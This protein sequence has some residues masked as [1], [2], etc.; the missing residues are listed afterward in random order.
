MTSKTEIYK[1][2]EKLF[3]CSSDVSSYIDLASFLAKSKKEYEMAYYVG[4]HSLK[5]LEVLEEDRKE[6]KRRSDYLFDLEGEQKKLGRFHQDLELLNQITLEREIVNKMPGFMLLGENE[7]QNLALRTILL[8]VETAF[9]RKKDIVA[10]LERDRKTID[11]FGLDD[12]I[13]EVLDKFVPMLQAPPHI[14]RVTELVRSNNAYDLC[15]DILENIFPL[16]NDLKRTLKERK[17]LEVKQSVLEKEKKQYEKRK[18]QFPAEKDELLQSVTEE[19]KSNP[20]PYYGGLDLNSIDDI[21]K[22]GFEVA[23]QILRS[24]VSLKQ[25]SLSKRKALDEGKRMDKM[26]KKEVF[27]LDPTT[28]NDLINQKIKYCLRSENIN[29]P[30]HMLELARIFSETKETEF[31]PIV[32]EKLREALKR[33]AS[34]KEEKEEKKANFERYKEMREEA[35]NKWETLDPEVEQEYYKITF[36]FLIEKQTTP[37]YATLSKQKLEDLDLNILK[38]MLDSIYDRR[39]NFLKSNEASDNP[40]TGK[41]L[42]EK[43]KSFQQEVVDITY[44]VQNPHHLYKIAKHIH[45]RND[46]EIV[47][48]IGEKCQNITAEVDAMRL[49][50]A[51]LTAKKNELEEEKADL[52]SRNRTFPASKEIELSDVSSE[53]MGLPEWPVYADLFDYNEFDELNLEVVRLMTSAILD[54]KKALEDSI[55]KMFKEMN[56]KLIDHEGIERD[57]EEIED[58]IKSLTKEC[59]DRFEN[60][61]YLLKFLNDMHARKETQIVIEVCNKCVNSINEITDKRNERRPIILEI[62]KLKEDIE[63]GKKK[64]KNFPEKLIKVQELEIKLKSLPQWPHF[65]DVY[66]GN[67]YDKTLLSSLSNALISSL[68][69]EDQTEEKIA[70]EYFYDRTAVDPEKTRQMRETARTM[71]DDMVD[72]CLDNIKNPYHLYEIIEKC[73]KKNKD[74]LVVKMGEGMFKVLN[75]L[76]KQREKRDKLQTQID[77]LSEEEELLS[78]RKRTLAADVMADLEKMREMNRNAQYPDYLT[79][80]TDLSKLSD[81]LT[82]LLLS[83]VFNCKRDLEKKIEEDRELT[84]DRIYELQ[85]EQNNTVDMCIRTILTYMDNPIQ[86]IDSC[87]FL[88]DRKEYDAAYSL[89][90]HCYQKIDELISVRSKREKEEAARDKLLKEEKQL[91]ERRKQLSPK[92]KKRLRALDMNR[93]LFVK[94]PPYYRPN[95]DYDELSLRLANIMIFGA[96]EESENY[97]EKAG[98]NDDITADELEQKQAEHEEKIK[99]IVDGCLKYISN[100]KNLITLASSLLQRRLFIHAISAGK[101]C[102]VIIQQKWGELVERQHLKDK[103]DELDQE[104]LKILVSQTFDDAPSKVE[105]PEDLKKKIKKAKKAI[106]TLPELDFDGDDLNRYLLEISDVVVQAAH[107]ED[108][109]EIILEQKILAFKADTS[110]ER[111]D[112][113][114]NIT[115]D[116][117]EWDRIKQDLVVY[118]LKRDDK[119]REK[120]ELLLRDGLYKHCLDIFP[121]PSGEED[122]LDLLYRVY[123]TIEENEPE[124]LEESIQIIARYMRFYFARHKYTDLT[125][126]LDRVQRRFP[127]IIIGLYSQAVD[128][129]LVNLLQSQY[130]DFVQCMQDLKNRL[131]EV[132]KLDDWNEFADKFSKKHKGKKRLMQMMEFLNDGTFDIAEL[133]PRKKRKRE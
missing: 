77:I 83:C 72:L 16:L 85:V 109:F 48:L 6:R 10:A 100:I 91:D 104:R 132:N 126:I 39:D 103:F 47:R 116:V 51:P 87:K 97:I 130:A 78:A 119:P 111:W 55:A 124:L 7:I 28:I 81:K 82:N 64:K 128:L 66:D 13:K 5:T 112:Q 105:I 20:I 76:E 92:D 12:K 118:V 31:I 107:A 27:Y 49:V 68:E 46:S 45:Q 43:K 1:V 11:D 86:L 19:L 121:K 71:I 8:M 23:K 38:F 18:T 101:R 29:D 17:E 50:R 36:D 114:R 15:F 122:E 65:A 33:I 30:N 96:V 67:Q 131:E 79:N 2:I 99:Q 3:G 73:M 57:R 125:R 90:N 129:V 98:S 62:E 14:L 75:E 37:S 133:R 113:V 120:C 25:T 52:E 9:D 24:A 32:G 21:E 60:P 4:E 80:T 70:K 44:E 123:D 108:L 95:V 102:E 41:F 93:R 22:Q 58:R 54:N 117:A 94:L 110:I 53:L 84:E 63:E 88:K 61:E 26:T 35:W 59:I 89:G 74:Y 34:T 69:F 40:L 127:S 106:E 56:P 42:E 115:R